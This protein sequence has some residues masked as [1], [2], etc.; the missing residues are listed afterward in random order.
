MTANRGRFP[1]SAPYTDIPKYNYDWVSWLPGADPKDGALVPYL[2]GF[3]KKVYICP[4]DDVNA[5]I[6]EIFREVPIFVIA[7]IV[8]LVTVTLWPALALTLPH[9]LGYTTQ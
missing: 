8:V 6:G 2:G 1:R 7:M 4:T 5:H 3:V 9:L